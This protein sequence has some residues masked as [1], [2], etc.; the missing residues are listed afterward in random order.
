MPPFSKSIEQYAPYYSVFRGPFVILSVMTLVARNT[1]LRIG[2]L[3][4]FVL[5]LGFTA[6]ALFLLTGENGLHLGELETGQSWLGLRWIS[7]GQQIYWLLGGLFVQGLAS[8]VGLWT[9][10]RMFRKTTA[11][12]VFFFSVFV[13]TLAI[14]LVKGGQLVILFLQYPP[15]YGAML[16][17]I[18]HFGHFLGIFCL[19]SSSLYL[20]G[21]EY[22]KTGIVLGLAALIALTLAYSMPVDFSRLFPNLMNPAG[23]QTTIQ[24]VA[25]LLNLLVVLNVLYAIA[26]VQ[27]PAYVVLLGALLLV[28]AGRELALYVAAPPVYAPA[29]GVL[30]VGIAVFTWRVRRLHLWR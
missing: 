6:A 16:T 19:L 15:I 4:A 13:F 7:G 22:Q 2:L 25:L 26:A 12:E 27:E 23:D 18:L 3:L 9:M 21:L 14:D 8:F 24:V 29:V 11:P 20:S 28:I 17:R 1:L 10:L 5:L 30:I